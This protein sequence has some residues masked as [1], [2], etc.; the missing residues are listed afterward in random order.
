M[1]LGIIVTAYDHA[2]AP[3]KNIGKA[4]DEMGEH[5][6]K[7]GEN[8]Q[9]MENGLKAIEVVIGGILIE[10]ARELATALLEAAAASQI[11]DLR[12]QAWAGGAKQAEEIMA[13]FNKT[14]GATGVTTEG[15]INSFVKFRAVG[16]DNDKAATTIQN[17]ANAMAAVGGGDV[18]AKLDAATTAFQRFTAKG[19]VSTRELNSIVNETGLTVKDLAT[20]SHESITKFMDDLGDKTKGAS[21]FI[22]A[23]NRAAQQKFGDFGALLNNTVAGSLAKF[24]KDVGDAF[25]SLMEGTSGN[26][27]ITTF[28]QNLDK[29]VVQLVHDMGPQVIAAFFQYFRDAAPVLANVASLLL[30]I[31]R[32]FFTFTD[33]IFRFL[34]HLP[35]E[36]TTYGVIGYVLFG[37]AGAAVGAILGVADAAIRKAGDDIDQLMIDHG[38]AKDFFTQ[39]KIKNQK[40]TLDALLTPENNTSTWRKPGTDWLSQ[41]FGTPEQIKSV[42]DAVDKLAHTQF[43]TTG[44]TGVP[45]NTKLENQLA[46]LRDEADALVNSIGD[47]DILLKAKTSGDELAQKIAAIRSETDGWINQLD[48][49]KDQ[50]DRSKMSKS[51]IL[52]YDQLIK[53]LE[54]QILQDTR[55]AVEQQRQLNALKRDE[56]DIQTRL[57]QAQNAELSRQTQRNINLLTSPRAAIFGGTSA[58]QLDEQ[59]TQHKAQLTQQVLQYNQQ[60]DQLLIKQKTDSKNA[61]DYQKQINSIKQ[62]RDLTKQYNDTLTAAGQAQA[63]FLHELGSAMEND[64]ASGISGLIQGTMTWGDVGRKVFSDLIDMSVKYLIQLAEM[65]LFGETASAAALAV[66]APTA[67]AMAALWEPAAMAASIA[68][69]G[70]AA[71]EGAAAYEIAMASA[72]MPFADGGVPSLSQMSSSLVTG[73]TLFG[74]AGEAGTEAIMPLTRIGGKL[75]VRAEGGGNH[76]S[77]TVQAIDTQSGLDFIGKHLS[78]IDAGIQHRKRVN[79]K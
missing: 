59:V 53:T 61:D 18:Q 8:T 2:T 5:I 48:K 55:D 29:M 27:E 77:I 79:L 67:L 56:L 71:A 43:P 32:A 38:I 11:A 3:F 45:G 16:L 9:A 54:G 44:V 7:A 1:D 17:L 58:G 70:T 63:N 78:H 73:P 14:I 4:A 72:I 35:Q 75:G 49:V 68:T 31:G 30:E 37:K 65:E 26:A 22:D 52:A 12:F 13:N 42:Q 60:I 21:A 28:I 74:M 20:A 24:K 15:L 76:Y 57:M 34:D 66:A 23:F 47:K 62:V 40:S 41:N 25:S 10:K 39:D 64:L 19:V 46:R 36:A 50:I 69:L 6:K 33:M 51:E